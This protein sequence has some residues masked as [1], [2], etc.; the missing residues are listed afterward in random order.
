MRYRVSMWDQK[1]TR[2]VITRDVVGEGR[3]AYL[4]ARAAWELEYAAGRVGSR[5]DMEDVTRLYPH[6]NKDGERVMVSIPQD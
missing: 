6:W 4:A 3:E 1:Q 5:F 2:V